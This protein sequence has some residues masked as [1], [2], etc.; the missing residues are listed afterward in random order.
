M[1]N[2]RRGLFVVALLLPFSLSHSHAQEAVV[3]GCDTTMETPLALMVSQSSLV[4]EGMA[5]PKRSCWNASHTLLLTATTVTVYKVFKGYI[6][7][8]QVEFITR[9]CGVGTQIAV[10]QDSLDPQLQGAG[11]FFG[12]PTQQAPT[13]ST[14]PA[15]Q[16]LDVYNVHEGYFTYR[17]DKT[18]DHNTA[19]SACRQYRNIPATLYAPIQEAA[20]QVY[21]ELAPFNID[22]YDRYVLLHHSQIAGPS[23]RAPSA[24]PARRKVSKVRTKAKSKAKR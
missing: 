23:P 22:T 17:G 5:G 19:F 1:H 15:T 24:L 2:Y 20:G 21:L 8:N 11:L 3:F 13:G 10:T 9:G 18:K 7:G 6:Q 14:L 16:V 12:V 4:V